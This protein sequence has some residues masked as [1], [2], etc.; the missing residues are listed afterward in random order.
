M[1]NLSW[2]RV[3]L[4]VVRRRIGYTVLA[5]A[6]VFASYLPPAAAADEAAE[7][8]QAE[9]DT[10]PA[11]SAWDFFRSW[12]WY[13]LHRRW[14][15]LWHGSQTPATTCGDGELQPNEQCDDGNRDSN[16][17]C[18]TRCQIEDNA[19]TPGDDRPGYV[20]C[21]SDADPALICSPEQRCCR[22]PE[23]VCD[24]LEQDCQRP[25]VTVGW[26]DNCD[27]PEDCE[28]GLT[29]VRAKYGASCTPAT[30]QQGYPVLCH[31]D[32]DCAFLPET[33]CAA[34]GICTKL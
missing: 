25:D 2:A 32:I 15:R 13:R 1:L 30:P 21:A 3:M 9:D 26:G 6:A 14:H 27:G 20:A 22:S 29:C 33:R 10:Q 17:G 4:A 18:D 11:I 23:N 16:D 8:Q 12:Y 24:S 19:S 31:A 34:D 7:A 28:T 5:F